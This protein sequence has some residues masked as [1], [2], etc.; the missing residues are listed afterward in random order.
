MAA[1][2]GIKN[3]VWLQTFC[4]GMPHN[5]FQLVP[6]K[7]VTIKKENIRFMTEDFTFSIMKLFGSQISVICRRIP[8]EGEK[9]DRGCFI[10]FQISINGFDEESKTADMPW[11]SDVTFVNF[12]I[13]SAY[14]IVSELKTEKYFYDLKVVVWIAEIKNL[15]NH[16]R[17]RME[18]TLTIA[19][20]KWKPERVKDLGY[21][22]KRPQFAD[23]FTGRLSIEENVFKMGLIL[24]LG[25]VSNMVAAYLGVSPEN[26]RYKDG[27]LETFDLSR[28]VNIILSGKPEPITNE[29]AIKA[30]KIA[31]RLGLDFYAEL[32]TDHLVSIIDDRTFV[33]NVLEAAMSVEDDYLFREATLV[34]L[35]YFSAIISSDQFKEMVAST[36]WV[37]RSVIHSVRVY[38]SKR[39][40]YIPEWNV[41]AQQSTEL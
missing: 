12:P 21:I 8:I 30:Y 5:L 40:L 20:Q 7:E 23:L 18:N 2:E 26:T 34:F 17:T 25:A 33:L 28:V 3:I 11:D 16:I 32:C 19:R 39:E 15:E 1:S 31:H 29:D 38:L 9:R 4:F 14:R 41:T 6:E 22:L 13:S 36:R 10:R 37:A 27:F 35:K 24:R